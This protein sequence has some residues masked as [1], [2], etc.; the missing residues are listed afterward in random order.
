MKLLECCLQTAA[1]NFISSALNHLYLQYRFC[2]GISRFKPWWFGQDKTWKYLQT[3]NFLCKTS[4][5]WPREFLP[6]ISTVTQTPIKQSKSAAITGEFSLGPFGYKPHLQQEPRVFTIHHLPVY[7]PHKE[8]PEILE[9]TPDKERNTDCRN[10][11]FHRA[12]FFNITNQCATWV[13][14]WFHD[15]LY[16]IDWEDSRLLFVWKCS[17]QFTK[18][19]SIS[20]LKDLQDFFLSH[21][22]WI[23]HNLY[24][25]PACNEAGDEA[26]WM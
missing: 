8:N 19:S 16:Y 2:P 24:S 20:T 12:S 5:R 7:P 22:R 11:R 1:N 25:R 17:L 6:G 9:G 26:V 15:A 3:D 21:S 23:S 13:T 4:W 18:V 10:Y 14:S